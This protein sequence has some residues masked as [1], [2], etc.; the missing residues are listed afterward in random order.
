MSNDGETLQFPHVRYTDSGKLIVLNTASNLKA[1]LEYAGY[2]AKHNKMTLEQDIYSGQECI[3]TPEV[4]RSELI[5]LASIHS[6]PRA[7]IDDHFAAVALENSY[8]P[9]GEWLNESWDGKK[10][11]D[12]VISCLRAKNNGL[13]SVVMKRWLVGCVASLYVPNFKSKLVP[14]LQGEQSF[15]KTAFVERIAT[16]MN[17][18][19]LE[20]SELNPDNKDNVLS[21]IRSWIVELGE[22]ERSTRNCQGA[23][24]AF[25]T[26][27]C[28]TIRPPY[29]RT[30]I[31]KPRQTNLIATVNGTDFLKDET[32]NSRYAVIELVK[33][34]DMSLLNEVLGWRFSRSGELVLI[35]PE[36]LKQFWLEVKHLLLNEGYAWTLTRDE[37]RLIAEDSE[38]YVDK[39]VWY[40]MLSEHIN[41]CEDKAREWMTTKQICEFIGINVSRGNAVGKALSLLSKEGKIERKL[42]NGTNRYCFPTVTPLESL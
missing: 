14:V 13:A 24:K 30:D 22:L 31:K 38:K 2:E 12:K 35:N 16:V 41:V 4:I 5:S 3:G 1:L 7:S 37:Q 28:D 34:T 6:L 8:H 33:E 15:R 9:I 26:R 21:V 36:R 32:G 27:S 17:G 19:F 18:A 29:A 39:G 42:L 20:G 11:V 23:L 10:R 40:N 25:I